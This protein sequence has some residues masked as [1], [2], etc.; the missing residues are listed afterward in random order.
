MPGCIEMTARCRTR[1]DRRMRPARC[2]MRPAPQDAAATPDMSGLP[3]QWTPSSLNPLMHGASGGQLVSNPDVL[4]DEGLYKLWFEHNMPGHVAYSTSPDGLVWSSPIRVVSGPNGSAMDPSVMREGAGYR[5]WYAV[6]GNPE[7]RHATSTDGVTWAEGPITFPTSS[8]NFDTIERRKQKVLFAGGLYRMW[9]SAKRS[10]ISYSIGYSTSA[11]GLTWQPGIEILTPAAIQTT[12]VR[13]VSV[14]KWGDG[15]LLWYDKA[16][17]GGVS[18]EIAVAYS[19]DG[20]QLTHLGVALTATGSVKEIQGS[21]T[22][23]F[24]NPNRFWYSC[25]YPTWDWGLCFAQSP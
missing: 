20:I 9:Y 15:F 21:G 14:V 8:T 19:P 11:D 3:M 25:K 10:S 4:Y 22:V 16:A 17:V 6:G 7:I 13:V 24:G 2:R 12:A 1:Q 23:M 5:M 18:R